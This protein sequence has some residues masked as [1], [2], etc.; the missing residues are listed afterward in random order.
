MQR[1]VEPA[2]GPTRRIQ[3]L[4]HAPVGPVDIEPE[5]AAARAIN[6]RTQDDRLCG[7]V[8]VTGK[9]RRHVASNGKTHRQTLN[10]ARIQKSRPSATRSFAY[11]NQS[12]L[13]E[14]N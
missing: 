6:G 2:I 8:V 3:P 14:T 10:F 1:A 9:N 12:L 13:A 5:V 4:Q 11:P 7:I